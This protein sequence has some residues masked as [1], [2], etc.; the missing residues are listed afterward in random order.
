MANNV[1]QFGAQE[2]SEELTTWQTDDMKR[3]Y[4]NTD[5][6]GPSSA[7]TRI[8]PTSRLALARREAEPRPRVVRVSARPILRPELFAKLRERMKVLLH[9]KLSWR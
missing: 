7:L 2:L 4:P 9:E 1:A 5:L 8:W 3:Q 6:D